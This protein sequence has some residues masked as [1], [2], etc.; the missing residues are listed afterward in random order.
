M[1]RFYTKFTVVLL[2]LCVFGIN[3]VAVVGYWQRGDL[4]AYFVNSSNIPAIRLEVFDVVHNLSWDLTGYVDGISF[5]SL[6]IPIT[7]GRFVIVRCGQ[8]CDIW[9]WD[10]QNFYNLTHTQSLREGSPAWSTDGRLAYMGCDPR[11]NCNVWIWDGQQTFSLPN[12][13]DQFV[14]LPLW[15]SDGRL[16][17]TVCTP[18][19]CDLWLWDGTQTRNI[20]NTASLRENYLVWRDDGQIAYEGCDASHAH[21]DIWLWDGTQTRNI[22]DTPERSEES[23]IWGDDGQLFYR[24]C[25]EGECDIWLWDEHESRDVTNSSMM[26]ETGPVRSDDGQL[27]YVRCRNNIVIICY[28]SIWDGQNFYDLNDLSHVARIDNGSLTW[29]SDGHLVYAGCDV[30]VGCDIWLWDGMQTI[31]L[32]HTP[33]IRESAVRWLP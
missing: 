6:P 10:R 15:S 31:R 13:Q 19:D 21:C 12:P 24:G 17:Y 32:T 30:Q 20:T 33:T 5:S 11:G 14:S 29:N 18:N 25:Q 16:A 22:T 2:V 8:D 3:I 26:D 28:L 7:D 9:L 1:L 23:P 27:L 4:L